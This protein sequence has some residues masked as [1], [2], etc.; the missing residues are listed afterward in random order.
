MQAN[1]SIVIDEQH[2]ADTETIALTATRCGFHVQNV[3]KSMGAIFGTADDS[4]IQTL[5]AIDGIEDVR[6]SADVQL[7]DFNP[8]V[9][10]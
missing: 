5:R 10:Q 8:A 9:P 2:I 3:V 7:P 6:K 1:Y 4:I